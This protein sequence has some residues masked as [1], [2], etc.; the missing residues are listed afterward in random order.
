MYRSFIRLRNFQ[1]RSRTLVLLA[2]AFL[3]LEPLRASETPQEPAASQSPASVLGEEQA[4][5]RAVHHNLDL[6]AAHY[7]IPMARADALTAGLW[8]NP[9]LQADTIFEPFG[10]NW[11]QTSAGGPRQFDV[12]LSIPLDLSEKRGAAADSAKA[13]T[14]IAELQF[15]DALRQKVLQV[16]QA[17]ID[18]ETKQS[19]VLLAKEKVANYEKLVHIIENRI[20]QNPV[21]PLLLVRARLAWDQARLDLRQRQSDLD[22]ARTL[23]AILL[24]YAPD[25]DAVGTVSELGDYTLTDI[26]NKESVVAEAL[27]LR[28]DL[29]ALRES[30]AKADLDRRLASH[31]VWDDF[32][33]TLSLSSQGPTAA[34]PNDSNAGTVPQAYSWDSAVSIPL[35]VFD[36]QQGNLRKAELGK[37]QAQKQ[38]EALE[39]SIKQELGDD[40]Q[41]LR[42]A[43]DLIVDYESSQIRNARQV[44]DSQQTQFG[45]GYLALL[46]YFD[47]MEAYNGV[48]SSY[49]DTVGAYRKDLAQLSASVGGESFP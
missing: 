44:R 31:Q 23:L 28:P 5:E 12:G 19:Q 41:Q 20:G 2:F 35:P 15:L 17:Y 33:L 4:V 10:P 34:S 13:A 38:V 7:A 21:R 37:E 39:L 26:P 40:L 9:A 6:L 30:V 25:D 48:L 42:V 29:L 27:A 36:H 18:L 46:D 32:N 3:A 45:T 1:A 24:G 49:Y 22:S 8:A 47:A 11:N 16:R 43:H 14:K